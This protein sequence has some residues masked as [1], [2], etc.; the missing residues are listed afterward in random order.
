MINVY[1]LPVNISGTECVVDR[2][3]ASSPKGTRGSTQD[4]KHW[5]T[6]NEQAL[7]Y[8][9][10]NTSKHQQEGNTRHRTYRRERLLQVKW[11]T[12]HTRRIPHV[13]GGSSCLA[14][15]EQTTVINMATQ[16]SMAYHTNRSRGEAQSKLSMLVNLSEA[17]PKHG[18]T[19]SVARQLK[20]LVLFCPKPYFR[21]VN[22]SKQ[23]HK[24]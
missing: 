5:K 12:R 19:L 24:H 9:G 22:R 11:S 14:T 8:Y 4:G 3:L 2:K 16:A 13:Y 10:A 1:S 7:Y 21:L 6:I 20:E 15:G 17:N 23:C 18:I